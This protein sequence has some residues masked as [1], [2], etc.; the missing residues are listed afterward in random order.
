[1]GDFSPRV[2]ASSNRW[3]ETSK[4]LWRSARHRLRRSA[5]HR[6]GVQHD[7]ASAFSKTLLYLLRGLLRGGTQFGSGGGVLL[8]FPLSDPALEEHRA[9]EAKRVQE[10]T[11]HVTASVVLTAAIRHNPNILL[12]FVGRAHFQFVVRYVFRS[13][14]MADGVFRSRPD[15]EHDE[16]LML[17]QCLLQGR[18]SDE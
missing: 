13:R 3:A 9:L 15:V 4:R 18:R 14:N 17:V 12:E 7:T 16:A 2:V 10:L 11:G 5:K 6:F 8:V 1:M